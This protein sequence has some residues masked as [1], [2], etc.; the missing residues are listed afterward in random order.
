MHKKEGMLASSRHIQCV[1]LLTLIPLLLT[2]F[3]CLEASSITTP[4][5]HTHAS[6]KNSILIAG[7]FFTIDVT[8]EKE[9]DNIYILA[10]SGDAIPDPESQS[11]KNYYKWEYNQGTW[12][13]ASGHDT[14]HIIASNCTKTNTTYSFYIGLATQA[15]PGKWTIKIYV[16]NKETSTKTMNVI[17]GNFCLFFSTIIGVFEP[18]NH[19]RTRPLVEEKVYIDHKKRMMVQ[20]KN[21]DAVV[22]GVLRNHETKSDEIKNTDTT[23]ITHVSFTKQDLIQSSSCTYHRS[24]FKESQTDSIHTADVRNKAGMAF[25]FDG[26]KFEG[27]KKIVVISIVLLLLLSTALSTVLSGD[28]PTIFGVDLIVWDDTDNQSRYINETITFYAQCNSMNQTIENATVQIVF[29]GEEVTTLR[30][31]NYTDGAYIYCR[32]FKNSGIHNYQVFCSV[33]GYENTILESWCDVAPFE[34]TNETTEEIVEENTQIP[35]IPAPPTQFSAVVENQ[36]CI[37]LSWK[38]G[39]NANTTYIVRGV[40]SYP[41]NRT[42]GVFVYNGTETSYIDEEINHSILYYYRAWSYA[43]QIVNETAAHQWSE[44][45][46]DILSKFTE[47]FT[48]DEQNDFSENNSL[49]ENET[50]SS[51]Y[52][53]DIKNTY[54]N[55]LLNTS[56]KAELDTICIIDKHH[57][58]KQVVPGSSFFVERIIDGPQ[59]NSVTFVPLFSDSLTFQRIEILE[60]PVY[61]QTRSQSQFSEINSPIVHSQTLVSTVC[62]VNSIRT[63]KEKNITHFIA[64]LP[65]EPEAFNRFVYTNSFDLQSPQTVRIWFTAPSWEEI[66]SGSKSA[67]GHISY[68]VFSSDRGGFDFE[69]SSWW[70]SNWNYR[71]A[72]NINNANNSYQMIINVTKSSGG[73]VTCDGYCRDDFGDI[74]FVDKDGITELDYWMES[75]VSGSYAIFWVETPSDIE[76]DQN[77]LMYYGNS[78]ASSVSNGQIL[79]Q[80][81]RIQVFSMELSKET[82]CSELTPSLKYPSEETEQQ[83]PVIKQE[84]MHEAVKGSLF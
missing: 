64:E 28:E 36:S 49:S 40:G 62:D 18:P 56:E 51:Y 57:E 10:Y 16:D 33:A 76:T 81:P 8:V 43:E 75:Y 24:K 54:E 66:Q 83:I 47:L 4:T 77:I 1:L 6:I 39:D 11:I 27:C 71:K 46:T 5:I 25:G 7:A 45:Y 55:N 30:P 38:K 69:G 14:Q 37:K 42:T 21:I 32:S 65:S 78:G 63:E 79:G 9:T 70:D 19:H 82:C 12:R 23:D 68:L 34:T 31:M 52:S 53:F 41:A 50:N 59:N 3:I 48:S 22:D 67:S 73:N 84:W 72:L 26:K 58:E 29:P 61:I 74:R 44:E 80:I 17:I 2:S 13:D 35:V 60:P 15:D 20:Q